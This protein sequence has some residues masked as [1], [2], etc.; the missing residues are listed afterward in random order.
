[1]STPETIKEISCRVTRTLL[2]Y[3]REK[4]NGTLDPLLDGLALNES[5]L[6]GYSQTESVQEAQRLGAGSYIKK[7]FTLEKIGLAVRNELDQR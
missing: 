1:M 6:S 4:N 7:P 3:V 2:L 5:Y